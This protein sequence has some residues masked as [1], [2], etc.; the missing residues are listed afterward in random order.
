MLYVKLKSILLKKKKIGI[1]LIHVICNVGIP[2]KVAV[3]LLNRIVNLAFTWS[4][5]ANNV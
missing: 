5:S 2:V 3:L 4:S 1:V